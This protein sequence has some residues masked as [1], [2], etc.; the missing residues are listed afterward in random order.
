MYENHTT[1]PHHLAM[2]VDVVLWLLLQ[3]VVIYSFHISSIVVVL[4]FFFFCD[5]LVFFCGLERTCL[6]TT[7]KA[8]TPYGFAPPPPS[9]IFEV[10]HFPLI[11]FYVSIISQC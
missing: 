3:V 10:G 7:S 2:H 8:K 9:S 5:E 11:S 4:S 6:I 1:H